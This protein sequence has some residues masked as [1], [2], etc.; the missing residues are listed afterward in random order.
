[1]EPTPADTQDTAETPTA[2]QAPQPGEP[3]L[4]E[5]LEA[6]SDAAVALVGQA[7]RTLRIRSYELDRRIYARPAMVDAVRSFVLKHD[8][9]RLQVLISAPARTAR[10]GGH[11]LVELGRQL[12]SRIEFRSVPESGAQ[13]RPDLVAI[14]SQQLLLRRHPDDREAQWHQDPRLARLTEDDFDELWQLASP[15]QE[16]R[17]LGI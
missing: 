6:F 17:R 1:M 12:S 9:A 7:E 14:D 2:V 16:L 8:R 3:Q 15:A 10:M 5:G 11:R 13:Q 4:L